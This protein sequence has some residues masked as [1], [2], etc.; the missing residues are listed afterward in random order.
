MFNRHSLPYST[1][2]EKRKKE[3]QNISKED[4]WYDK[5]RDKEK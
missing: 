3:N 5:K 1:P 2:R 4:L